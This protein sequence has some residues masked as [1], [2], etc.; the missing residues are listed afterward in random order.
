ME[1]LHMICKAENLTVEDRALERL[2]NL[3]CGD[4]RR[5][6]NLLQVRRF[7]YDRND[8]ASQTRLRVPISAW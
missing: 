5:A 8:A 7:I 4:L 1:R 3:T 2:M 6:V